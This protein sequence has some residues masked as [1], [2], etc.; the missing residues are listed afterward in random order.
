MLIVVFVL[1]FVVVL[2]LFLFNAI[3]NPSMDFRRVFTLI[4]Y[5]QPSAS[6]SDSRHFHFNLF[7]IFFHS[8]TTR[9]TVLTGYFLLTSGFYLVLH[10]RHFARAYQGFPGSQQFF[11]QVCRASCWWS[12][13]HRHSPLA[14]LIHSNPQF[15]YS[16]AFR[17]KFYQ[18]LSWITCDEDLV[19]LL[20]TRC[21]LFL[22]VQSH[23]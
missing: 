2:H 7:E 12:S 22:L 9:A 5:F 13:K 6:Q 16:E 17:F 14:C 20:L 19:Y 10:H 1:H 11:L 18:I 8:L 15:S 21:E 23:I 4:L 3:P